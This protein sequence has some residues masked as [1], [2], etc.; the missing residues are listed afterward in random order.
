MI[1]IH[2]DTPRSRNEYYLFRLL[3][4]FDDDDIEVFGNT[5]LSIENPSPSNPASFQNV[6][7]RQTQTGYGT[8]LR[9]VGDIKDKIVVKKRDR[10]AWVERKI[11][12]IEFDGTEDW[13]YYNPPTAYH[14]LSF[15]LTLTGAI[16]A[17]GSS[18]CNYFKYV[19]NCWDSPYA[20]AKG[21]YTDHSYAAERFFRK[22]FDETTT[23]EAWK[24]WVAE[25]KAA[26]NPLTLYY[27]LAQTVIEDI[28]FVD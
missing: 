18:I 14:G 2:T 27:K 1:D 5:T 17:L 11:G 26:N 28:P 10:T 20:S 21:M 4:K 6:I 23:M 12:V 7:Y 13:I 9:S 24:A 25:L 16:N 22:P 3:G 8:I 15:A 19:A